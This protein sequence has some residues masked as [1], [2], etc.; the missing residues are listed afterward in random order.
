MVLDLLGVGSNASVYLVRDQEKGQTRALKI[1]DARSESQIKRL[2]IEAEV[3]STLRHENVVEVYEVIET[4][5]YLGLVMEF[6]DGP[7]LKELLRRDLHFDEIDNLGQGI[8]RGVRAA[9]RHRTIHRDLKPSNILLQ[10]TE[11]GLIP[12]VTDFGLA[13]VLRPRPVGHGITNT[14]QL[15]GSPPYMSPEQIRNARDVDTRADVFSLGSVLYRMCTGKRPFHADDV[16]QLM[17]TIAA[18]EYTPP[19]DVVPDLPKR[20]ARAI[21]GALVVDLEERTQNVD[22]LLALWLDRPIAPS[23]MKTVKLPHTPRP[24]PPN[25]VADLDRVGPDGIASIDSLETEPA[26][27]GH[28]PG[29]ARI[30]GFALIGVAF[31]LAAG[32][33]ALF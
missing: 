30:F 2:L 20:M 9:H 25:I 19:L 27:V 33:L 1:L 3:Q 17:V 6:I 14:G 11:R 8:L 5:D 4:R 29:R 24:K 26:D 18:G 15:M 10:R 32:A 12:K 21:E 28:A 7:T 22:H 13:K 23:A 16:I 31:V